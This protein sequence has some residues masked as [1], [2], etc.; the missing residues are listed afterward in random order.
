MQPH[1]IRT[2]LLVPTL[3]IALTCCITPAATAQNASGVWRGRWHAQATATRPAHGGTLNARLKQIGPGVY[4]GTFYGR[5]AV[6]VPYVYRTRVYQCGSQLWASRKI[7]FG[8]SYTMRLNLS[9]NRMHGGWS[10][11]SARGTIFLRRTR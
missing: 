8:K 2:F 10:T 4:R 11:G 3:S 9:G 5:F 6:I 7:G 1:S